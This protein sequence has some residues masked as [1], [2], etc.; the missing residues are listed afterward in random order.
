[1]GLR[2][3]RTKRTSVYAVLAGAGRARRAIN[4]DASDGVAGDGA[5]HSRLNN[6]GAMPEVIKVEPVDWIQA[7]VMFQARS[8]TLCPPRQLRGALGTRNQHALGQG[9]EIHIV[10]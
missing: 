1:S 7:R 9:L 2:S 4:S 3:T 6:S 5:T 10:A 8:I